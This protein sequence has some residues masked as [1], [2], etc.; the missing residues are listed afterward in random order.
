MRAHQ[1][2]LLITASHGNKPRLLLRS[3]GE[4]IQGRVQEAVIFNCEAG[5][6]KKLIMRIGEFAI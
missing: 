4:V 6:F 5:F 2:F 1:L 3:T